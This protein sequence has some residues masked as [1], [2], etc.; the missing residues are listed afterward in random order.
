MLNSKKFKFIQSIA[1]LLLIFFI[2]I[3]TFLFK[4]QIEKYAITGY[5]GVFVA[6]FASTASILLPAPGIIVVL[7]YATLLNPVAVIFIGGLGTAFGEMIGYF[8][9]KNGNEIIDINTDVKIFKIFK[10]NSYFTVFIFS[11]IPLPL[12]DFV[13]ICAGI[14][15][16][17]PIKFFMVCFC[18]KTLK[19]ITYVL[20]FK[21]ALELLPFNIINENFIL[22]NIY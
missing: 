10:K 1:S 4:D 11:Y 17:N 20:L 12:F 5:F 21:Y 18:G 14:T 2:I 19:M 9:G 16:L 6:C 15:N 22:N 8:L 3:I 13:G 7:Q